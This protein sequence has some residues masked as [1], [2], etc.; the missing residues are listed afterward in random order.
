MASTPGVV[1]RENLVRLDGMPLATRVPSLPELAP[2]T[3]VNLGVKSLDLLERK[4]EA[5]YRETL[6]GEDTGTDQDVT[7]DAS[8][9]P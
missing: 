4:L 5:V 1:L 2:G 6:A 8:Q 7:E 9:K 3:R